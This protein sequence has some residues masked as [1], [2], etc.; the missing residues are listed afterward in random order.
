[1]A[2]V[3]NKIEVYPKNT[4]AIS[5]SV[6]GLSMTGYTPYMTVKK[7]TT[8]TDVILNKT[9]VVRDS[10]T[11]AFNLSSSDN[12]ISAGDYVYDITV[13]A[14]SSIYT[15]VKDKFIVIDGVKY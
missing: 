10:S 4:T 3:N 6:S 7:K 5:C 15:V 11:L 12:N 9:G 14:D 1:M 2:I 8:D 13:I